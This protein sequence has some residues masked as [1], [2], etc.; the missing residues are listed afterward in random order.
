MKQE[1]PEEINEEF[2]RLF[3]ESDEKMKLVVEYGLSDSDKLCRRATDMFQRMLGYE[4]G[5]CAAKMLCYGG[6]YIIGGLVQKN[7]EKM[8]RELILEGFFSKPPHIKRI[9]ESIPIYIVTH[10]SIEMAGAQYVA[11]RILKEKDLK[12]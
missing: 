8:N 1:H 7:Y 12:K 9:F 11:I 4:I 3:N 2:D 10:K 6:I 5:N